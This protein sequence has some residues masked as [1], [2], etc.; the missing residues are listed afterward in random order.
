MKPLHNTHQVWARRRRR[1]LTRFKASKGKSSSSS[2]SNSRSRNRSSTHQ[3]KKLDN[4]KPVNTQATP[5]KKVHMILGR[6][7]TLAMVM[8]KR[9]RERTRSHKN[10]SINIRRRQRI[11][12][13]GRLSFCSNSKIKDT[14]NITAT[15]FIQAPLRSSKHNNNPFSSPRNMYNTNYSQCRNSHSSCSSNRNIRRRSSNRNN[16]RFM[17]T[18]LSTQVLY[19][20]L[21][22]HRSK[23]RYKVNLINNSNRQCSNIHS[24]NNSLNIASHISIISTQCSSRSMFRMR[25]CTLRPLVLGLHIPL[26]LSFFNPPIRAKD[27]PHYNSI[28]GSSTHSKCINNI[29][30]MLQLTPCRPNIL[31]KHRMDKSS[32]THT[33]WPWHHRCSRFCSLLHRTLCNPWRV[34]TNTRPLQWQAG[35]LDR[36]QSWTLRQ[37]ALRR[38]SARGQRR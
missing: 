9:K 6:V 14:R 34:T 33:R 5:S 19:H 7:T 25:L 24:N 29:L 17:N 15:A 4:H 11:K 27:K 2:R 21:L 18:S 36:R 31:F 22:Y 38:I 1:K 20:K 12:F 13:R 10:Y 16:R 28:K 3:R 32:I 35:C 37:E 26:E 8:G 23:P 30:F